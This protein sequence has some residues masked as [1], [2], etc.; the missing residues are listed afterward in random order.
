MKR[1]LLLMAATILG[2][3][4][5][6]CDGGNGGNEATPVDTPRVIVTRP[7]RPTVIPEED[8]FE[9]L[10][11]GEPA[12][13][14]EP[15]VGAPSYETDFESF[16]RF[17]YKSLDEFWRNAFTH[18]GQPYASPDFNIFAGVSSMRCRPGTISATK[19]GA[20][21]CPTDTTIYLPVEVFSRTNQGLPLLGDFA[22]AYV[23]AHEFGHHVQQLA[24]IQ[25]WR[26]NEEKKA[27]CGGVSTSRACSDL[28]VK[29]E[30]QADCLAGVWTNSIYYQ[31]RL[32]AGDVEEAQRRT[33]QTGDDSIG[34]PLE[35]WAHGA[36]A[37]RTK[38]F[39]AGYN[40]GRSDHCQTFGTSEQPKQ[41]RPTDAV[42]ELVDFFSMVTQQECNITTDPSSADPVATIG[43]TFKGIAAQLDVDADLEKWSSLEAMNNFFARLQREHPGAVER[44]WFL[45]EDQKLVGRTLEYVDAS[46][47]ATIFWTYDYALISGHA[48][49]ND[50]DQATL[51]QWW[52][53]VGAIR[54]TPP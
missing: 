27:A 6:A 28:S 54:R 1:N 39:M 35:R 22:A 45:R 15:F 13:D 41:P 24:K 49:R 26:D 3:L 47:R 4:F 32:Q 16:V 11:P 43:C 8:L 19:G 46:G 38:W 31:G 23:I 33:V 17:V 12:G 42:Q 51:N 25:A 36:A 50:G 20:A 14:I 21:Y 29:F 7:A 52:T 44:T 48:A 10:P 5:F 34:V 30:L 2:T 9:A 18:A 37:D 40:S 53:S